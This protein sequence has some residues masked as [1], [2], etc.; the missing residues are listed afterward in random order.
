MFFGLGQA[1]IVGICFL[2]APDLSSGIS[3]R[4]M[5]FGSAMTFGLS[6]ALL[7]IFY[8]ESPPFLASKELHKEAIASLEG[9]ARI[10]GA[11]PLNS[12]EKMAVADI[13]TMRM[14][15]G[16]SKLKILYQREYFFKT[17]SIM[18]LWFLAIFTFYGI[19]LILPNTLDLDGSA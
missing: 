4:Y 3:W 19:Y 2:V 16:I 8:Y 14:E 17:L 12:P 11:A 5:L 10:N 18:Y 7:L 15:T 6:F 1:M 9:I 13:R